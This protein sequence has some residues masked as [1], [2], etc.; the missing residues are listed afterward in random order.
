LHKEGKVKGN[1]LYFSNKT[2][3]DV[4]L[5]EEFDNILGLNAHY[6][7]TREENPNYRKGPINKQFLLREIGD[8][9]KP[10]YICGPDKMVADINH[11]LTELGANPEALVFEK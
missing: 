4:I 5:K 3:Q 1:Q 11:Q 6:I 10:F 7:L 8:F 2:S 9:S